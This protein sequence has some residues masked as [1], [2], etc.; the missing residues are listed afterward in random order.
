MDGDKTRSVVRIVR[1]LILGR[2]FE[3]GPQ[4][5]A[6]LVRGKGYMTA[7]RKLHPGEE[8]FL[9]DAHQAHQ[10]AH[11]IFGKGNYR[12]RRTQTGMYVAY[13]PPRDVERCPTCGAV[14]GGDDRR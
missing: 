14:R 2:A 1:A 7:L 8:V 3:I 13:T 11:R 6:T 10:L 12:T 4:T 9:P 5:K